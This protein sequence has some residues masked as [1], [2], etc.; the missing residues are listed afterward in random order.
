MATRVAGNKEG[1]SKGS[2]G[3][4]NSNKVVGNKE[5]DCKG[6]KGKSDGKDDGRQQ[7]G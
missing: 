2:K 7:R 1:N 3:N 5:G 6:G 4:D